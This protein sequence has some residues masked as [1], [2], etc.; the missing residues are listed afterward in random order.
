VGQ[1]VGSEP[2]VIDDAGVWWR[3]DLETAQPV[4]LSV[5]GLGGLMAYDGPNCSGRQVMIT[6]G[7]GASVALRYGDTVVARDATTPAEMVIVGGYATLDGGCTPASGDPYA[8]VPWSTVRAVTP[9]TTGF[10]GPLRRAR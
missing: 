7:V 1:I 10:I 4:A 6:G 5:G 2:E 3:L 8:A 9:P